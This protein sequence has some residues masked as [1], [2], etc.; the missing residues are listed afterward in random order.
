MVTKPGW[1]DQAV[2][3]CEDS[4]GFAGDF[5]GG[6]YGA[7]A[8]ATTGNVAFAGAV[9][10]AIDNQVTNGVPDLCNLPEN[11]GLFDSGSAGGDASGGG[12]GPGGG[13]G[14]S[15]DGGGDF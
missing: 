13:G 5:F 1:W 10:A 9:N 2:D 11:L 6:L 14:G 4:A 8:M 3:R 12:S 15:G 7:G